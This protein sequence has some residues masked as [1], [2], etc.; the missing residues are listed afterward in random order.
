MKFLNSKTN[1]FTDPST[2]KEITYYKLRALDTSDTTMNDLKNYSCTKEL[3]EKSL[4]FKFGQD[5]Q[6]ILG[7]GYQGKVKVVDI[8]AK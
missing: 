7:E 3:Y 6:I 1:I 4:N 8:V 5:I 2:N